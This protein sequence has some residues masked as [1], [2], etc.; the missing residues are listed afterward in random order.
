VLYSLRENEG[1]DIVAVASESLT[2]A[3]TGASATI[4]AA[5]SDVVSTATVMVKLYIPSTVE[6]T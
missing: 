6:Y 3:A 1:D 2:N 4:T 5:A